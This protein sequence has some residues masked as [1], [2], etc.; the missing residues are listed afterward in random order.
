[1][2][3]TV[4]VAALMLADLMTMAWVIWAA[5]M[6]AGPMLVAVV[7]ETVVEEAVEEA[8]INTAVT[9]EDIPAPVLTNWW[10]PFTA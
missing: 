5:R 10:T 3:D 1:M 6:K 9:R 2:R 4:P 8:L 7:V